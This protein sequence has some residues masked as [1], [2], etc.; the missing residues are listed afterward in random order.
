MAQI[1]EVVFYGKLLE[2]FDETAVKFQVAQL[3][4]TGL[5][6][7]ERMF[8][9]K[10]VVIRNKLDLETAQKYLI[11]M[12][13]RG[14]ECSIEQMGSPGTPVNPTAP[15]ASSPAA[16][17]E[18]PAPAPVA[19]EAS[20]Q[21]APAAASPSNQVSSPSA[22]VSPS[23]PSPMRSQE[24]ASKSGLNLAGEKAD[25]ILASVHLDLDPVGVRLAEE[26][27]EVAPDLPGVDALSIAPTGVDLSDK[28][29]ETPAPI[30]DVSHLSLE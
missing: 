26:H 23:A 24:V 8:T 12:K 29:Q 16:A 14:A 3:F 17:P 13:K 18:R 25:E 9:G 30:P 5:D 27:E 11:A 6:Q 1:Y 10:R 21:T 15:Q 19:S 4:K 7:V 20:V 28:K 22:P 2:G